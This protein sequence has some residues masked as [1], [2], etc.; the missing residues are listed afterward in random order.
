MV[1]RTL[2]GTSV[3][4]CVVL[5][6][7]LCGSVVLRRTLSGTSSHFEWVLRRTLSGTSTNRKWL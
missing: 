7:T 6:R 2:Y 3:V 5:R 1:L 4:L